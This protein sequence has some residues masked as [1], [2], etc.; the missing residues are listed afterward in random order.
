MPMTVYGDLVRYREL[1]STLFHRDF[2]SKYKGSA[3][4]VVWSL[5]N[6]LILMAV[7]FI[8]FS[9]I[10]KAVTIPHYALFLLSGLTL[11]VFFSQALPSATRSMLDNAELIRKTRFPRQLLPFSIVATHLVTLVVML[12]V[13]VPLNAVLLP[14]TRGTI[15]LAL[16]LTLL[17]I[18][19]TGGIALALAAL[20]VLYR[21]V[22]HLIGSLLLPWFFLTPILYTTDTVESVPG[23]KEHPQLVE[24]V[25]WLNFVAPAVTAI[26]APLFWGQLPSAGDTIYLAVSAVVALALGAWLFTRLDD[27]IAVEL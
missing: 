10:W 21:D 15:L 4:G 26:R 24:A 11:W 27:R 13:I 23:V 17:F 9:T 22:E 25:H 19:L 16:P 2:Q 20:N 12:V 5:A 8:V 6:P 3:L 1:F 14:E 18:C 7:Y